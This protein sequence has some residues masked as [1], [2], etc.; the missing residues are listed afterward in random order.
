M[1]T[2]IGFRHDY[3]ERL[4]EIGKAAQEHFKKESKLM[5]CEYID[6]PI[7]GEPLAK[8]LWPD[9]VKHT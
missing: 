7:K 5:F 4:R 1:Y 8:H 6:E 2:T 3:E 9:Y